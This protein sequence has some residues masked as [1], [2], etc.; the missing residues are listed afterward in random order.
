MFTTRKNDK[1]H[2]NFANYLLYLGMEWLEYSKGSYL[3]ELAS[4]AAP[5]PKTRYFRE[6]VDIFY[7]FD[8]VIH[9]DY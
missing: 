8:K 7:C 5:S 2:L 4:C 1:S 6:M 9:L 3:E